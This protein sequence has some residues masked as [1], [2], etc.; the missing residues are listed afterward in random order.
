MKNREEHR[1]EAERLLDELWHW[2]G[3]TELTGHIGAP[4]PA[5]R[6]EM[7]TRAHAHALLAT[8]RS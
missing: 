1:T 4:S 6:Q 2:E 3:K 5:E 8:G 7:A